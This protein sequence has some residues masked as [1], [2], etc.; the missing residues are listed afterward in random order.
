MKKIMVF[1]AFDILHKGHKSFLKQAK[2]QG[3]YL[4]VVI[5]RDQTVARLK[6]KAVRN[7]EKN[8]AK[9][10]LESG[11]VD[12]VVLGQLGD[13]YSIIKKYTPD[14]ICLGYDQGCFEGELSNKLGDFGLNKT[15]IVRLKAYYPNI[16][17]SSK[18]GLTIF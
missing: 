10:V 11:L 9:T 3:T 16:Y 14:V 6:G 13:K 2:K 15:K 7:S 1:G 4:I 17:K 12:K 18:L 5:A 8:R